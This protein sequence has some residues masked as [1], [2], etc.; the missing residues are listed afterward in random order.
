MSDGE[1]KY[2]RWQKQFQEAITERDREA[3]IEKIQQFEAAVFVRLQE[4]SVDSDHH[5]ERQA[6]ADASSTLRAVKT[7]KLKYPD[8][9]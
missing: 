9:K 8:W 7:D 5:D 6:I 1:I 2:P 4:L 3:L